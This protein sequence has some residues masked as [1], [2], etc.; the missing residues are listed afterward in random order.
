MY[1]CEC[2]KEFEK[3]QSFNAHKSN[4]K[5]HYQVKYGN[6]DLFNKRFAKIAESSSKSL[7]NNA[8]IRKQKALEQ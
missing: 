5:I 6:L 7:H 8:I 2:G 4:C 3:S 1:K